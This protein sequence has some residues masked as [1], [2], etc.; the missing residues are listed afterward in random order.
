[1]K[2]FNPYRYL[3]NYKT[4]EAPGRGD[5]PVSI[6]YRHLINQRAEGSRDMGVL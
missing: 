2:K 3:I 1:M 5:I 4:Y 6:P